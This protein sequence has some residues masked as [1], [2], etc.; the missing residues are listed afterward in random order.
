MDVVYTIDQFY[1]P[2]TL[3]KVLKIARKSGIRNVVAYIP[4]YA[5]ETNLLVA[6]G[7]TLK[8]NHVFSYLTINGE[9]VTKQTIKNYKKPLSFVIALGI[10]EASLAC[11]EDRDDVGVVVLIND[12][13]ANI[14]GWLKLYNATEA[15]TGVTRMH[16][17]VVA[18]LLNRAIGYLKSIAERSTPLHDFKRNDYLREMANLL[19]RN[20]V[21][22][23]AD[24]VAC[25]C[26]KRGLDARSARVVAKVF[27][28]ALQSNRDLPIKVGKPNYDAMLAMVDKE[29][30]DNN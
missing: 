25:L 4:T 24:D 30:Y 13:I 20:G 28:M 8:A 17:M 12:D 3:E 10:D 29:E 27:G 14:D 9:I 2:S 18:P 19:R 1:E 7:L 21:I 5:D 22:Y 6:N 16:G 15:N 11:L 23:T 26:I